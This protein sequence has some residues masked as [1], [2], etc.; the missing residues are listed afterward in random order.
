MV[1]L[2]LAHFGAFDFGALALAEGKRIL[3]ARHGAALRQHLGS[4]AG[5]DATFDMLLTHVLAVANKVAAVE[6][7]F[8]SN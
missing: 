8:R 6:R 7:V 4:N 5:I 1:E 3:H 2:Q